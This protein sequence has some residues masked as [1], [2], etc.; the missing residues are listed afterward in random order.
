MDLD[1]FTDNDMFYLEFATSACFISYF[2]PVDEAL[3]AAYAPSPQ[4]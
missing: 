3:H 4:R 1:K 2:I